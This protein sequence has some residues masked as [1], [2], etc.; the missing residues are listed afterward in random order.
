MTNLEYE[1]FVSKVESKVCYP[2]HFMDFQKYSM[3]IVELELTYGIFCNQCPL[4]RI[5]LHK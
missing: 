5:L 3:K 1:I 2:S 4:N